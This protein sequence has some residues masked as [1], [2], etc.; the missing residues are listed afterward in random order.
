M[1]TEIELLV[2]GL[3]FVSLLGGFKWAFPALSAKVPNMMWPLVLIALSR[4]G[5][6]ACQAVGAGCAGSPSG[7]SEVELMDFSAA[8]AAVVIREG[9]RSLTVGAG[10]ARSVMEAKGWLP[11]NLIQKTGGEK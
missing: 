11:V 8:A 9:K 3:I 4:A 6:I 2:R 1:E 5:T 10:K 7:W